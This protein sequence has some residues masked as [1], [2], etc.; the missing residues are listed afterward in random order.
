M[1]A[2]ASILHLLIGFLLLGALIDIGGEVVYI[3]R[4][5]LIVI[6]TYLA[7][8]TF[9][10]VL[11]LISIVDL[12]VFAVRSA[13]LPPMVIEDIPAVAVYEGP[14]RFPDPSDSTKDLLDFLSIMSLVSTVIGSQQDSSE[15]KVIAP[16]SGPVAVVQYLDIVVSLVSRQGSLVPTHAH[17]MATFMPPL[18]RVP[19]LYL[20]RGLSLGL[21]QKQYL[22]L[23]SN[24]NVSR[25]LGEGHLKLAPPCLTAK[26]VPGSRI[27]AFDVSALFRG[28]ALPVLPKE[29]LEFWWNGR[30]TE[31]EQPICGPI[32]MDDLNIACVSARTV[33]VSGLFPSI[34][35]AHVGLRPPRELPPHPFIPA[36][37]APAAVSDVLF[38]VVPHARVCT[39]AQVHSR[40]EPPRCV[41]PRQPP[42]QLTRSAV[43][44]G[45]QNGFRWSMDS[46]VS[47]MEALGVGSVKLGVVCSVPQ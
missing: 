35:D 16:A 46:G 5:T 9:A 44:T 30:T 40:P 10:D 34:S 32:D 17:C 6:F 38:A 20:T 36:P 25:A 26:P 28:Q 15:T 7:S 33:P 37:A 29:D 45:A 21:T 22:D 1:E 12:Q 43:P 18:Y 23:V 42:I 31:A 19:S 11:S 27:L 2:F 14:P 8:F 39:V 41:A 24:S 3:L 13:T 4:A 47:V